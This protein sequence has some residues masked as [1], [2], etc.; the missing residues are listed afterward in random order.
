MANPK[1]QWALLPE[2]LRGIAERTKFV[3][4]EGQGPTKFTLDVNH[5]TH[6]Y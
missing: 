5:Q 1:W 3:S 6:L 4:R 2:D